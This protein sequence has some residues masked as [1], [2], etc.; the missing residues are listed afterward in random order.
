MEKQARADVAWLTDAI[1][2]ESVQRIGKPKEDEKMHDERRNGPL[3][4]R[5]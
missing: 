4:I 1:V 3:S 5:R 2:S